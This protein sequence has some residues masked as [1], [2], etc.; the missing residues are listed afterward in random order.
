M[1]GI[2]GTSQIQQGVWNEALKQ[3]KANAK[4]VNNALMNN[5]LVGG[6]LTLA[7]IV[8]AASLLEPFQTILDSGF[9]KGMKQTSDWAESVYGTPQFKKAFGDIKLCAKPMKPVCIADQK[10]EEKKPA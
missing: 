1:I 9:R 6:R 8:V 10:K 2:F 3:L 4:L 7:D 5:F